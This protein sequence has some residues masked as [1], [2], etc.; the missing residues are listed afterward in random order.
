[1]TS[2]PAR[3]FT[4]NPAAHAL[5]NDLYAIYRALHDEFGNVTNVNLGDVMK[6]LLAIRNYEPA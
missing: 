4:P 1:M 3:Q 6:R 2:R 5:Y